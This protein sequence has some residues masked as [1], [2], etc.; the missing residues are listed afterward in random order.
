VYDDVNGRTEVWLDDA[1]THEGGNEETDSD[2]SD[3][4]NACECNA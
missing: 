1:R 4:Y 2:T 3:A